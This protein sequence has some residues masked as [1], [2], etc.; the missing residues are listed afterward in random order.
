MRFAWLAVIG[1]T[2]CVAVD[3]ASTEAQ[4]STAQA[5]TYGT[6]DTEHAPTVR[7]AL[8]HETCSATFL[9]PR[10]AVTAAHCIAQGAPSGVFTADG[11]RVAVRAAIRY[12]AFDPETFD[13]DLAVLVV[14]SPVAP[15][16][17]FGMGPTAGDAV[18]VVGY[19]RTAGGDLRVGSRHRGSSVVAET[20]ALGFVTTPGPSLACE[21]DS[22]GAAFVSRDGRD[23]LVGVVSR[24]D[25]RCERRA[26]FTRVDGDAGAF[27]HDFVDRDEMGLDP[28]PSRSSEG[29]GCSTAS[30][31]PSRAS[32]AWLA[33]ALLVLPVLLRR[34]LRRRCASGPD[35]RAD[36]K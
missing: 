1:L 34:H 27:L 29:G 22:G 24:G 15:A 16:A 20:S 17:A 32:R 5:V 19:G 31:R 28:V 21:G 18:T 35:E 9:S 2:S 25:A 36:E 10:V 23:V 14:A 11:A 8:D 3:E 13:G 33:C 4:G 30:P 6:A 26:H 7:V 12:P